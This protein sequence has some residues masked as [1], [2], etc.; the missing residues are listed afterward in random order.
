MSEAT[1]HPEPPR[2][3]H[4]LGPRGLEGLFGWTFFDPANLLAVTLLTASAVLAVVSMRGRGAP[5]WYMPL[6]LYLCLAV[7]MRGYFFAYYHGR[8]IGRVTVLLVLLFG[9]LASAA[10]WADRAEPHDVLR[11]DGVA[12]LPP[13]AGFHV[14][15][16]LHVVIA[17]TLLLHL[18]VPRRWMIRATDEIA[19]RS[20]RDAA[21]DAPPETIDGH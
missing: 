18:L 16:L 17:A 21:P 19:D 8:A 6:G 13:A 20:G 3:P 2:R 9:L 7:F 4:I 11:A 1:P 12:A 5:D 15:A 14:A 10:L